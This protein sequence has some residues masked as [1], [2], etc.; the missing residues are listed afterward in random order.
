MKRIAFLKH[1]AQNDCILLR[2]GN[3]HSLF[4]NPKNNRKS[5]VPRHN[6]LNTF[7]CRKICEQLEMDI[8]LKK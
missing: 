1:L 8:I 5:V 4:L 3:K 7:T 6:E 2:E